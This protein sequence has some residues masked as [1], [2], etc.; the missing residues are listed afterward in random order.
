[1]QLGGDGGSLIL[2]SCVLS[3]CSPALYYLS[4]PS[5]R[6][7]GRGGIESLYFQRTTRG[8]HS[9]PPSPWK[10]A[11]LVVQGTERRGVF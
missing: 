1:M 8:R 4:L 6:S 9:L 10:A 7:T 3:L 2:G 5:G 11:G